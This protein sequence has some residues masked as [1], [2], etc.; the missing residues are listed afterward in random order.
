MAKPE[1]EFFDTETLPWR[2]VR[3]EAGVSQRVLAEDAA[4][5]RLTRLVR[6]DPGVSTSVGGPAAHEYFEEVLILAGS[7]RDLRLEQTFS[8]GCY[9]CRPPGMLHGPWESTD[10]CI[11]L[12]IRYEHPRP[13]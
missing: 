10:G 8:A 3:G 7:L 1:L 11:M 6:W 4:S 2:P 9:A 5:G 13:E 12:E